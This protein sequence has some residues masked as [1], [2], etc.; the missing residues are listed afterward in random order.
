[1]AYLDPGAIGT[2]IMDPGNA[3]RPIGVVTVKN[4]RGNARRYRI[5]PSVA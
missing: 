5:N 4:K 2:V 1:M 3:S